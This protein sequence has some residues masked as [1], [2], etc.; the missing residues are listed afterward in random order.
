MHKEVVQ[1]TAFTG[2]HALPQEQLYW[3]ED[4]DFDIRCVRQCMSR[5][6]FLEI[7]RYLHPSIAH[8]RRGCV[9]ECPR[10]LLPR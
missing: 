2:Y 10:H 9:I 7:K 4:E 1:Y 5:N 8:Q 3:N 6:M